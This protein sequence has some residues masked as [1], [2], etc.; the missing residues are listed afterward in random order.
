LGA[1]EE[2]H[3]VVIMPRVLERA[4]WRTLVVGSC[5]ISTINSVGIFSPT[6]YRH[7]T[8]VKI[9]LYGSIYLYIYRHVYP[10]HEKNQPILVCLFSIRHPADKMRFS[11]FFVSASLGNL[12]LGA[13]F[14]T[15]RL[16]SRK[17]GHGTDCSLNQTTTSAPHKNFWGSLTTQETKDVLALLHSNAAGFNLTAA[18]DA[19]RYVVNHSIT[20]N[21]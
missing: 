15:G 13:A 17:K 8:R 3:L 21:D 16:E 7:I 12:A 5:V 4:F 10:Q 1:E 9:F 14:S 18:A 2:L 19:G 11:N 6:W 20:E